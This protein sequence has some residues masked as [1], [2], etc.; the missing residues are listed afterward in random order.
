MTAGQ[1]IRFF[2]KMTLIVSME[3]FRCQI[4]DV[5]F[6][7]KAFGYFTPFFVLAIHESKI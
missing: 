3:V 7:M 2:E 4:L 6:Q 1:I 5:R